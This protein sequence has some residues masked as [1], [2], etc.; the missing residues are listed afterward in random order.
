MP[1]YDDI[2]RVPESFKRKGRRYAWVLDHRNMMSRMQGREYE[3]V[4]ATDVDGAK[5]KD[6]PRAKSVDGLI[7]VGDCILMSCP[8]KSFL[9]REEA[10]ARRAGRRGVKGVF[11]E[12]HE[13]AGRAGVPSFEDNKK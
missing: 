4:K 7:R 5:F 11:E 10:N 9:E 13:Q 12:F 6:D 2:M 3:T 1:D 8:E